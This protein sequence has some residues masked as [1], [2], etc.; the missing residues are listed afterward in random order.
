LV[1]FGTIKKAGPKAFK[2][3]FMRM[4][5]AHALHYDFNDKKVEKKEDFQNIRAGYEFIDKVAPRVQRRNTENI[6]VREQLADP[7][8]LLY[9]WTRADIKEA[10]TNIRQESGHADVNKK[11]PLTFCDLTPPMKKAVLKVARQFLRKGTNLLGRPGAGKTPALNILGSLMS[12][13]NQ[14]LD[15]VPDE[16][17][18]SMVR[19]ANDTE[20]FKDEHGNR[21]LSVGIDDCEMQGFSMMAVKAHFDMEAKNTI[22]KARYTSTTKVGG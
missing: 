21:C 11:Y 16:L 19:L 20:H 13:I 10:L 1:E 4:G 14:W 22:T 6:W 5:G 3:M 18:E 15:G 8:S 17:I 9:T 2:Y 12:R 7:E